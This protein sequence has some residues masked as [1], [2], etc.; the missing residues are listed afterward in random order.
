MELYD[1]WGKRRSAYADD[2]QYFDRLDK[3]QSYAVPSVLRCRDAL[4]IAD[5]TTD[6]FTSRF[7]LRHD[8]R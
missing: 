2:S 4:L 1:D 6:E 5:A 7:E 3:A 8:R